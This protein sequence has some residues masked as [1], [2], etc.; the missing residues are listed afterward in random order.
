MNPPRCHSVR[1]AIGYAGVAAALAGSVGSA[2]AE[3]VSAAREGAPA[4]ARLEF[5]L[6]VPHSLTL[7]VAPIANS[8]AEASPA[9]HAALAANPNLRLNRVTVASNAGPVTIADSGQADSAVLSTGPILSS[10]YAHS[11]PADPA[12]RSSPRR[13]RVTRHNAVWAHAQPQPQALIPAGGDG[14]QAAPHVVPA[15]YIAAVP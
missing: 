15:P 11:D 13:A 9:L 5:R 14:P 6:V 8:L 2:L 3:S 1:H 4:T 12:A 7:R 10:A